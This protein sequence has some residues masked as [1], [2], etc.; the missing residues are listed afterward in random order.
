MTVQY[1]ALL[2]FLLAVL[3]PI[4]IHLFYFRRIRKVEFS[5]LAFLKTIEQ[6][7]SQTKKLK[8]ILILMSRILFLVFLVL[9]FA[10]L[11]SSA[12]SGGPSQPDVIYIDNSAS[13]QVPSLNS[14]SGINEA[15]KLIENNMLVDQQDA[16]YYLLTNHFEAMRPK[17]AIDLKNDLAAIRPEGEYRSISEVLEQITGQVSA[18]TIYYLSDFQFPDKEVTI[19]SLAAD[20]LELV[21]VVPDV[22]KNIYVDTVYFENLYYNPVTDNRLIIELAISGDIDE[23]EQVQ[24]KV[25]NDDQLI[26]AGQVT[27]EQSVATRVEIPISD[28]M[29]SS[30]RLVVTI[31]DYPVTYDNQYYLLVPS[32]QKP[33]ITYLYDGVKPDGYLTSVFSNTQLFDMQVRSLAQVDY[34][35]LNRSDL[36]ILGGIRSVPGFVGNLSNKKILIIPDQGLD[37]QSLG[38]MGTRGIITAEELYNAK[39]D[40][41]SLDDPF[42]TGLFEE[43]SGQIDLPNVKIRFKPGRHDGILLLDQFREPYLTRHIN[44]ANQTTYYFLGSP[45][46]ADYTNLAI[47]SIF[48]PLM[49]QM[50]FN[51]IRASP[52]LAYRSDQQYIQL[53]IVV[54]PTNGS[55]SIVSGGTT[56]IPNQII[57]A[58]KTTLELPAD[59]R[60]P[61]Y[62]II[63]QGQDTVGAFALNN[64]RQESLLNLNVST[65]LEDL[66]ASSDRI[67]FTQL[68]DINMAYNLSSATSNSL[69]KYMLALALFFLTAEILLAR[70]L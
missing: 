63:M 68:T 31:E 37:L 65:R 26:Y 54:N 11:W 17:Y 5:N 52:I 44:T 55:L 19:D 24:I 3:I 21:Q 10:D 36:I 9:A 39:L 8:R 16:R 41:K 48:V 45:L 27:L 62:Y 43:Q 7:T 22:T 67:H 20:R 56:M 70:F 1:P 15:V 42:F 12:Q 40:A 34:D 61:G 46:T 59:S 33:V 66:A 4:L 35:R 57:T 18:G 23:D 38:W 6:K 30:P 25:L 14:Q 60:I 58:E 53:P 64:S 2:W 13:M 50:A 69:W 47:H 28:V 29:T 32:Y 49:Y 51:S